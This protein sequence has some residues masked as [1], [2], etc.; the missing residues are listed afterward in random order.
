MNRNLSCTVRTALFTS[1]VS[2]IV[3]LLTACGGG[4]GSSSDPDTGGP[5]PGPKPVS[6]TFAGDSNA[7]R[8]DSVGVVA[9]V[10][11]SGYH[12]FEWEQIAGPKVPLAGQGTAGISFD[13]PAADTYAF[14]FTATNRQGDS[15]SDTYSLWVSPGDDDVRAHL[16]A[17]RAVSEGAE[18]SLRLTASGLYTEPDDWSIRQVSGPTATVEFDD[19]EVVAFVTAPKVSGDR[20]LEFEAEL[21]VDGRR[22]T[23]TAYVVVQDRPEVTSEYFCDGSGEYCGTDSPLNNVYTYRSDSPYR[24]YLAD[25]VYSN[26]LTDERF[27]TLGALPLIGMQSDM[28]TVDQIMDHVLVSHDWM[29]QRF[30]TFL[31]EMDKTNHDFARLLRSTTA[32]VI[33]SDIRPSFYWQLTGA[34]YLDPDSLWL[35]PAER[36]VINEQPDY[37]SGFGSA[38]QFATPWRYVKNNNYAFTSY[39]VA[40]RESRTLQEVELDLGSLMYHELAHA[41]DAMSPARID[42]GLDESEI[43]FNE[44]SSGDPVN[45]YVTSINPLQ[46]QQLFD[47]AEVRYAG[48]EASADQ[49]NYL[50]D[51]IAGFFFPDSAN[52]FYAYSTGWEDTA[53]LFE[54]TMMS[55]RYDIQRDIAVTNQPNSPDAEDYVVAQGQRNRIGDE[56]IRERASAAVQ[57]LLPEAWAQ[58]DHHLQRQEVISLCAGENWVQNLNPSCAGSYGVLRYEVSKPNAKAPTPTQLPRSFNPPTRF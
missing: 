11:E 28:P 22:I 16:R 19:Y 55:L 43:F 12:R 46:S 47:L 18:F 39:P 4:G 45:E 21:Q 26:Q 9:A 32:I 24:D 33:S 1:S 54:E 34:I 56:R 27:C 57:A 7:D 50:A 31:R 20:V 38:L 58:A 37:R 15:V 48:A 40:N 25:C 14:S 41:N 13:A 30:E 35:T 52:D 8:Y 10:S 6:V 42:A 5:A 49:K 44:A 36:D 53:M 23:D 17:D 2:L 29:G 51:D 3:S